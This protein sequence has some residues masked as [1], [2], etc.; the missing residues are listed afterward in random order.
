[1]SGKTI[2]ILGAGIGGLVAAGELR[3]LLPREHRVVLVEKNA[4]HAFAPSFLWLMSG[5]RQPEQITCDVRQLAHPD[6]EVILAEAQTIDLENRAV[7][8]NAQTV[9]YD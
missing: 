8:T 1:M 7:Q 9:N 2:L 4:R 5:D 3:R 6:V